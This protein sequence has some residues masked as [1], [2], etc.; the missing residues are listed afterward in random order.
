[1]GGKQTF[2]PGD[3]EAAAQADHY[4]QTAGRR[5]RPDGLKG[6]IDQ[7]SMLVMAIMD[8]NGRENVSRC[9]DARFPWVIEL[10]QTVQATFPDSQMQVPGPTFCPKCVRTLL[11][12]APDFKEPQAQKGMIKHQPLM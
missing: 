7:F 9:L 2:A 10:A 6:P 1:M 11:L 4:F 5:A 3:L 8:E 12:P